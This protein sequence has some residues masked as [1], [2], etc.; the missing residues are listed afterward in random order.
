MLD[1]WRSAPVSPRLRATL[2]LLEKLTLTPDAVE[3]GDMAEVRAAGVSDAAITDAI[4]V[5][6]LFNVI[7]RVADALG[8][9]IPPAYN[10]GY[11]P[12]HTPTNEES[13]VM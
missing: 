4:Y 6:F 8:F 1:D 7:D 3:P 10:K 13:G 5:C 9:D 2:G 11:L 12:V